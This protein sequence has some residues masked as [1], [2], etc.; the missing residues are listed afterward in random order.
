MRRLSAT[1]WIALAATMVLGTG[2][3]FAVASD[4]QLT[5]LAAEI[6]AGEAECEAA[7][8]AADEITRANTRPLFR[9]LLIPVIEADTLAEA[10]DLAAHAL[11]ALAAPG[12]GA[13]KTIHTANRQ[14][15]STCVQ[16]IRRAANGVEDLIG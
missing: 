3:A 5:E 14:M 4:D 15:G 12:G 13:S 8:E 9:D 10:Q 16:V 7:R 6:R 1:T 2:V 11:N